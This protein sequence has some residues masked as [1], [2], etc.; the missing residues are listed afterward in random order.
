MTLTSW[1]T[2]VPIAPLT[3]ALAAPSGCDRLVFNP[4][5]SV[6]PSVAQAAQPSGYR[7]DL[8]VPQSDDAY[9]LSTPNL[10]DA[11]V[12]LPAGVAV[13]PASADGL[14][15]CTDG[16]LAIDAKADETCPAASKIGDVTIDTP[17][18]D[19]PVKGSIFLGTQQ[20][21]TRSPGKC[22]GSF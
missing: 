17:L 11:E 12:T 19:E 14:A 22:T 9:R 13:S 6:T 15:G 20:S 16:Q 7:V 10:K 8:T 1:Q 2:G 4:A 18:L 3:D 21:R 5:I